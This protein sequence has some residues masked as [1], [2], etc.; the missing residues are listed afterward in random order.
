MEV[1]VADLR[2]PAFASFDSAS[3][4][5][6]LVRLALAQAV[7]FDASGGVTA[8]SEALRKRPLV[9]ERG[10][11]RTAKPQHGPLLA[12]AARH[13]R[14]ELPE[15]TREP[16]ALFEMTVAPAGGGEVADDAE[17]LLRIARLTR[18][19]FPVA[20][21]RFGRAF[22]LAEFMRRYTSEPV[23]FAL[24]TSSA[25]ELLLTQSGASVIGGA[26]RALGR[27]L[28]DNVRLYVYPMPAE[29]LRERLTRAG[30]DPLTIGH[31][32]TGM[33]SPR[34]L[35]LP[36]PVGH[37]L[38]YLLAAGW[39]ETLPEVA[40]SASADRNPTSAPRSAPAR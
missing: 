12:A 38:D 33:I 29:V 1:D 39:M 13:L 9:V 27:L 14:T 18:A 23:R 28:S 19:G 26:L 24:G 35:K 22:E 25:V 2:G 21:T 3:T 30:I 11:Y 6:Q 4:A 5:L 37:M 10:L 40:D 7:V 34:G 16:L 8:P 17:L 31:D 20:V 32:A 15:K 36:S